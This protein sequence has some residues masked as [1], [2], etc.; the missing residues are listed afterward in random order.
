MIKVACGIIKYKKKYIIAQRSKTKKEYPLC[1]E[2]PGGKC[3]INE[4]ID[5]C[6]I[7]ELKEELNLDVKFEKCIYIRIKYLN[8]YDLY[9]CLCSTKKKNIKLNNEIEN[10]KIVNKDELLNFNFIPGDKTVINYYLNLK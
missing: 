9:Y 4:S 7:R 1:W 8:K 2:L 10:Y 6:L 3:E 5:Q